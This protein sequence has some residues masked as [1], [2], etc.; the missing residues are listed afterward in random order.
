MKRH[1]IAWA[2]TVLLGTG[3]LA[4]AQTI[5]WINANHEVVRCFQALIRIDSQDPP[6]NETTVV[7]D[8][9]QMLETEGIP[10]TVASKDL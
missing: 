9:K 7:N 2:L 1:Q 4:S 10:M 8:I 6:G 3:Q 5:D